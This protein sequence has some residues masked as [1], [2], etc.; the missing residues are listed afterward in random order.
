M[1]FSRAVRMQEQERL[2][3]LLK[4]TGFWVAQRFN[5]AI[6]SFSPIQAFAAEVLGVFFGKL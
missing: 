2:H 3:K 4:N 1:A 6:K 5:A